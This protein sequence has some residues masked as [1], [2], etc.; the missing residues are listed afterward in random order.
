MT[1]QAACTGVRGQSVFSTLVSLMGSFDAAEDALH[2]AFIATSERLLGE[3][4]PEAAQDAQS[5]LV[6]LS[7]PTAGGTM[8]QIAQEAVYA[9]PF[10]MPSA[11]NH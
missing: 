1:L 5:R 8:W 4:V 2:D 6:Q 7:N 3:G 10:G 11:P 9:E